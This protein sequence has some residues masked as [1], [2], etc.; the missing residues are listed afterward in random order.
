MRNLQL[1]RNIICYRQKKVAYKYSYYFL[2]TSD[3]YIKR[4]IKKVSKLS[5]YKPI[6]DEISK[7]EEKD[8]TIMTFSFKFEKPIVSQKA[9]MLSLINLK[10]IKF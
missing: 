3:F 9:K 2:Q 8:H 10:Q 5:I 7:I 4:F 6:K 1:R